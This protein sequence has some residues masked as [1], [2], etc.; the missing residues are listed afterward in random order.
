MSADFTPIIPDPPAQPSKGNYTD[1]QPFRFWCQKVLPLVY[2]ESLSY[3]EVLCKLVDYLNKTMEDVGVLHDDV[4][5]MF[6]SFQALTNWTDQQI[7][8]VV[9]AY[10][11]LQEYV[12]NYFDNLDV[13]QEINNKLDAMSRSGALSA[14][15]EPFLPDLVSTWLSSHVDPST[16][17][18]V[19]DTLTIEGAAADAKEVGTRLAAQEENTNFKL[20]ITQLDT[21]KNNNLIENYLYKKN[22]IKGTDGTESTYAGYDLYKIDMANIDM[23]KLEGDT[24]DPFWGILSANGYAAGIDLSDNT[25]APIT[26]SPRINNAYLNANDC[27]VVCFGNENVSAFYF[28]VKQGTEKT[29]TLTINNYANVKQGILSLRNVPHVITTEDYI[30]ARL[31]IAG[32]TINALS[33]PYNSINL[34]IHAGDIITFNGRID[35]L[36]SNAIFADASFNKTDV[37]YTTLK[38]VAPA[39]GFIS[40]FNKEEADPNANFYPAQSFLDNYITEPQLEELLNE[41]TDIIKKVG[42]GKHNPNNL[43][44]DPGMIDSSKWTIT[45]NGEGGSYEFLEGDDF[46]NILKI[47]TGT[48]MAQLIP[49]LDTSKTNNSYVLAFKYKGETGEKSGVQIVAS[50]KT[51]ENETIAIANTIV[52]VWDITTTGWHEI[53]YNFH[54]GEPLHFPAVVL[55]F[56]TLNYESQIKDFYFGAAEWGFPFLSD[57][58][59]NYDGV[60]ENLMKNISSKR[61]KN[62]VCF[63]DS[64]TDN[65][66]LVGDDVATYLKYK[67]G[68][69]TIFDAGFG[70]CQMAKHN[71]DYYDPFSMYRLAYAIANDDWSEQEDVLSLSPIPGHADLKIRLL[72]EI[73]FSKVDLITIAYGTN[74]WANDVVIDNQSDQ[75]DTD[76]LCGALRYSIDQLQTAFPQLKIVVLSCPWR[77]RASGS[78]IISDSDT[79]VNTNGDTLIDMND[80]LKDVAK[81]YHLD[82]IDLYYTTSFNRLTYSAFYQDEIHQGTAG[83][84]AIA[85]IISRNVR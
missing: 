47:R 57:N 14:L 75:M 52:D 6:D 74:D 68:A 49:T 27:W 72:K 11:Q 53:I 62:L 65:G 84:E 34:A 42:S 78:T 8:A 55:Y 71:T 83:R 85:D 5:N 80:A 56:R 44:A 54:I 50:A 46:S 37:P 4:D 76:T 39:D 40:I 32:S 36:T 23:I 10:G 77:C 7:E 15:I 63:G 81:E 64:L 19:D 67:T 29:I 2:D 25:Y 35:T 17:Y 3:Y 43:S 38:F 1:L 51:E 21:L 31:N 18:V 12:N 30:T 9:T 41:D 26:Y 79:D 33:S 16:G 58:G 24:S 82:F 70:G 13:Q 48:G 28:V 61:N 20:N 69:G 59:L 66:F 73:D 45:L 60:S 22:T